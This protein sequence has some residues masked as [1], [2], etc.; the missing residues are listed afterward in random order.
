MLDTSAETYEKCVKWSKEIGKEPIKAPDTCGF[1]SNRMMPLPGNESHEPIVQ[2]VDPYDIDYCY[3]LLFNAPSAVF[4]C[5][6]IR[7]S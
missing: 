3:K 1:I 4:S 7:S 6:L 2:G 5:Y